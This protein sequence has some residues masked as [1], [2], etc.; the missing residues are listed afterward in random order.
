[1]STTAFNTTALNLV[2]NNSMQ[3]TSQE[4]AELVGKRHDNVKRTI[5][6]MA[7]RDI[8]RAPQIEVFER[9]NNLGLI[10][11]DSVYVFTG[12]KGK[13]DSIIVVA[14]L[15]PEF[16][17]RLVDRWQEL[18]RQQQQPRLPQNFAEA[19]MLAAQLEQQRERL[20]AVTQEQELEIQDRDIRIDEMT[21]K[22]EFYD[23]AAR[24]QSTTYLIGDAAKVLGVKI[25]WFHKYLRDNGYYTKNDGPT[26][27]YVNSGI[28]KAKISTYTDRAGAPKT[29][30]TTLL[31]S[32]GVVHLAKKLLK[33]GYI[34][35]VQS[36]KAHLTVGK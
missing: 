18:E 31:T 10:V 24:D 5:T 14:Q 11:K 34:T 9:I 29:V 36:D 8:I 35:P 20:E 22:E 33:G 3:M 19:L 12:E 6:N 23:I 30:K 7:S 25:H 1:M 28:M 21:P 27:T 2:S 15:C 16:T 32:K 13:R 17:A 26:A 4:I